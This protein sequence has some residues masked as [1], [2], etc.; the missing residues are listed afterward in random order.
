MN[1]FISCIQGLAEPIRLALFIGS[2]PFVDERISYEEVHRRREA[3]LLPCG[4]VPIITVGGTTFAQTSAILR[5]AGKRSGLWPSDPELELRADM[6]D[7]AMGDIN[8]ALRPQWY[9]HICGRSPVTGELLVPMS[10][11]QKEE[12]ARVLNEQVL[13]SR[14]GMLE[15]LLRDGEYFC[16]AQMSTVDL[17]WACM[18]QDLQAGQYAQGISRDVLKEC[19]RLQQLA[20]RVMQHPRVLLWNAQQA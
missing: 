2:V 14:L 19:P 11:E 5:W 15:A 4:Q 7:S 20:G 6:V 16:G 3:G 8:T 13:P 18:A 17:A 9:G 1:T 12:T 10:E